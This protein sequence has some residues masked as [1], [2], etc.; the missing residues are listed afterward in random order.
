[1]VLSVPL[2]CLLSM[3]G[4]LLPLEHDEDSTPVLILRYMEGKHAR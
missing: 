2:T 1:M 4:N 3:H